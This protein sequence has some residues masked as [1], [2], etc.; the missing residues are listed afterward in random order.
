MVKSIVIVVRLA[1]ENNVHDNVSRDAERG[2]LM[3]VIYIVA[4]EQSF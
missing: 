1:M 4:I 2:L 3:H